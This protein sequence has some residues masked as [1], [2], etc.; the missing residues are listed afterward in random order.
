MDNLYQIREISTLSFNERVLQEAEDVRN[1]LLERLK[2][3][4]IFSSNMDEFFKVRVAS[5]RRRIEMG[6]RGMPVLLEVVTRKS[7]ELDERFRS[8][9][10]AI[11][12]GLAGG[13]I[14]I[15]DEH[16]IESQPA[17]VIAWLRDYFHAEVLPALVPIILSKTRPFPS[18]VDGALYFAV[19]MTGKK[20]RYALLE[21]PG[22]IPRFVLLP[23]GHIMYVDDV[24][25]HSLNDI[26][27]IFE[28]DRIE[29]F[30]FK[31]SRDAELDMDNDFSE[32]YIRKMERGLQKRK[33][34]RPVRLVYDAGMPPSLLELLLRELKISKDD[35]LIAGGRYHNMR[36]LMR[37][38]GKRPDFLFERMDHVKHPV[39]DRDRAPMFD[40]LRTGDLLITYPYQ[41]FDHLIRLLREAAIDPRV[42]SIAMTLYRAAPHSQVVNAL[43]NAAR[44]GKKVAVSIEL[45]ARFDEQNNIWISERLREAGATVAYGVPTMKVHAKLLHIQREDMA[46]AGLS[47]GN[48]NEV[49]GHI[50]VD[51]L[52]LTSDERL[53]REV[54]DVLG[55]LLEPS[56]T[57]VLRPPKFKHLL[58]SPINSR[59]SMMKFLSREQEKGADG[60]VFIKTNHLTDAKIIKKI[61][62]AADAGVRMDLVVRTTYAMLPHPNIRA[63]SILDRFLEHQR[64]YIFGRGDDRLVFM[65]SADLMERNLDWRVEVAFPVFDPVLKGQV[66]DMM[67]LQIAD[68]VKARILD[69]TQS[70][71][72]VGDGS[73]KRRA[74]YDTYRYLGKLFPGK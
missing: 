15:L 3:L 10:K 36:D 45:Q 65:S 24:I 31:I 38:P 57:R 46:V 16:D 35:P 50:Y 43:V 34:G 23:N 55:M 41:E 17:D 53:T 69:E 48:F 54:Q 2:F 7:R 71:P 20:T 52:L 39:L 62:E 30:E 29:A 70:N 66:C 32:G 12:A 8:A 47:T 64:I 44:N 22:G 21:I 56:K 42:Q 74:Q 51:S 73:G 63:I 1:P 40:L 67:N 68:N 26:F 37:F 14:K 49:T 33:G 9:Y 5:I 58:V 25:R 13:G 11:T 19:R 60:Y 4:G 61:V 28:Y 6:K 27:Y 59:K 72:Y 18:L